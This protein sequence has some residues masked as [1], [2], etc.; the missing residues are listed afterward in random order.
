M[1]SIQRVTVLPGEPVGTIN[2]HLHG[3]FAEHLGELIYP[4]LWVGLD[5]PIPNTGGIRN[6]VI[7][8][9]KPL[10]IPVLRWPGGLSARLLLF[11]LLIVTIVG[12]GLS[13]GNLLSG[14]IASVGVIGPVI[15]PSIGLVLYGIIADANIGKLLVGG[16]IPGLMVT[17]VI[18]ATVMFLVWQDPARAP[19]AEATPLA[20]K[21]RTLK[22]TVPVLFLFAMVTGTRLPAVRWIA[23]NT[24]E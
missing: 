18:I 3:H 24:P 2:P 11:T 5:S 9:L 15:P 20:V 1:D 19:R 8:A 17:A 13:L 4:G 23:W 10:G 14:L 22:V 6:D 12:C 21:L 16:V 7:E